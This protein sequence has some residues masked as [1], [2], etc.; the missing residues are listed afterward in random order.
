M[1]ADDV[2][3]HRDHQRE[4]QLGHRDGR[5]LGGVVD[6]DALG[7]G[8]HAVDVVQAHAAADDELEF[9]R[10]FQ[11]LGRALG[12]APDEQD[13]CLAQAVE[14]L[15]DGAEGLEALGQTGIKGVGDHD[16]HHGLHVR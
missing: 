3:G 11:E 16:M 14:A 7:L 8:G 1:A 5:G 4:G 13:I 2:V 12:L 15:T 6:G 10:V 9:G